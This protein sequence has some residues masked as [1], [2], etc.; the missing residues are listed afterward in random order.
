MKFLDK[1]PSLSTFW[2]SLI[3]LGQNTT[4]YKFAPAKALL[5]KGSQRAFIPIDFAYY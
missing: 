1:S 2:R 4:S 3:L 5:E